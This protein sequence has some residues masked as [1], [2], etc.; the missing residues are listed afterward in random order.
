MSQWIQGAPSAEQ[1]LQHEEAHP[2][3][4]GK[5]RGAQWICHDPKWPNSGIQVARLR[6]LEGRVQIANGLSFWQPLDE[7]KWSSRAKYRPVD[8]DGFEVTL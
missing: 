7:C 1:V 6:V 2:V 3:G 4:E 5:M 8:A